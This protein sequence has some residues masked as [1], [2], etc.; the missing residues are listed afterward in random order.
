MLRVGKNFLIWL[1]VFWAAL[2]VYSTCKGR[3]HAGDDLEKSL[4]WLPK[5]SVGLLNYNDKVLG[6][7]LNMVQAREIRTRS[8]QALNKAPL[9]DRPFVQL[10]EA[11]GFLNFDDIDRN[12][13][14]ESK[15]R[16]IR[17][18]RALRALVNLDAKVG[19]Y[20]EA[21]HHLDILLGLNASKARR[22]DYHNALT[23]LSSNPAARDVV[24]NYLG[25][26]APW[27]KRFL[28][29]QISS[30]TDTNFLDVEK[31]LKLYLTSG[32]QDKLNASYLLASV[33]YTH[34]TLPTNREV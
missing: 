17:N 14:L 31:S 30:M 1:V 16:N 19:K 18:R 13:I 20:D 10:G 27:G 7:E 9:S 29:T 12:L 26:K 34:L 22:T 15:K 28:A 4:Q 11:N 32:K 5:Y 33:S 24:N 23:L 21:V 3:I 6:E 25:Q 8:I 2:T